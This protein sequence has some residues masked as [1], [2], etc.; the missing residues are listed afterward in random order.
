MR[1][2]KVLQGSAAWLQQRV[3]LITSSRVADMLAKPALTA[4]G[5]TRGGKVELACKRNYRIELV[6]ER[7]TGNAAEHYVSR[8]MEWGIEHEPLARS[9]YEVGEDVMVDTAGFVLHPTLDYAGASPDGL[10]NSNGCI[11]IKCPTT[12]TYI[13][14]RVADVVPEEHI[15][16]MDWVMQCCE[17]EWCDFVAFDPRLPQGLRFFVKRL[18][19][20]DKR[21]AAMELEAIMFNE[22]I[23]KMCA[24]MGYPNCTPKAPQ[25]KE[26]ST[27]T[28]RLGNLDVPQDIYDMVGGDFAG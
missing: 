15:P 17:R 24:A 9:A 5:K 6:S 20:D 28:V 22:E 16:Q 14:W 27:A 26:V 1:E 19:R 10:V 2:I 3:G 12:A 21:I 13:A 7:L 11:E 18:W 23:E 4:S 25:I 8:E